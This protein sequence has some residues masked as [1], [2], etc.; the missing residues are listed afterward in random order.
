MST[1]RVS[2]DVFEGPL[3]LLLRLIEREELDI[4][5]VSLALVAD[6]FLAHIA[7]LQGASAA[8]LADFLSIGA[9]LVVLKSRVLLPRPEDE[10]TSDDEDWGQDLVE[11]LQEYRRYKEVAG[12]LREIE[13]TNQ[14]MYPRVAPPPHMERPLQPGEVSLQQ[15]LAALQE[16]LSAHPPSRPVDDVVAPVMVRIGDCVRT[17]Q[18]M[19]AR[20][21]RVRFSLLMRR[22][23]SRME[24]IVTFLAMLELIKQQRLRAVQ[25]YAFEEIYLEAREPDV[26]A[27]LEPL[28]LSEYGEYDVNGENGANGDDDADDADEFEDTAF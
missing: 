23:H 6:Q 3:D 22:A 21:G 24:I 28:D 20:M 27:E 13:E 19:T 4:T 5:L 10:D 16:V 9:R 15:L 25:E 26:D 12:R 11:R 14:R 18:E 2:L 7:R 17:I 8:N 1:Y